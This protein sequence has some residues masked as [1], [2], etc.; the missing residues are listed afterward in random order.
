MTLESMGIVSGVIMMLSFPI[1]FYSMY[2]KLEEAESYLRFSTFIVMFKHMFKAGLFEG[3]MK[4]LFAVALVILM[5]AAFQW[6]R[7]VLVED[8]K[9]IPIRLKLWMVMPFLL[10]LF[11]ITGMA[12][13]WLL[14]T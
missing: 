9:A 1:S 12:L 7:L 11:S 14:T 13:S 6:R 5:P 2:T 10:T 4:R 3:R 8:V